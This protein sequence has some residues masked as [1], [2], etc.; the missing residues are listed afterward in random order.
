MMMMIMKMTLLTMLIMMTTIILM[1]RTTMTMIIITMMTTMMIMTM[2]QKMMLMMTL[3]KNLFSDRETL[4][5]SNWPAMATLKLVSSRTV[6]FVL[7]QYSTAPQSSLFPHSNIN[8][9]GPW[10]I[11]SLHAVIV[12]L[13]RPFLLLR[14]TREAA[15]NGS[16]SIG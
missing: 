4:K 1:M 6:I 12:C 13:P 7:L 16:A 11:P 9:G 14:G 15:R 8:D 2:R 5:L 10:N 3:L